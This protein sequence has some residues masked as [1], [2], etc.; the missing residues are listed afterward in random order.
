MPTM[1]HNDNYDCVV[2]NLPYE[3]MGINTNSI[4]DYDKPEDFIAKRSNL[5]GKTMSKSVLMN[6]DNSM[7][8][9]RRNFIYYALMKMSPIFLQKSI[10][11]NGR[12][13][14]A[15]DK[16]TMLYDMG[17]VGGFAVLE[18]LSDYTKIVNDDSNNFFMMDNAATHQPNML[19]YPEFMPLPYTESI[20][21]KEF[22]DENGN[23]FGGPKTYFTSTVG[24]SLLV[25]KFLDYLRENGVYDNTRIIIVADHGYPTDRW[26]KYQITV[27]INEPKV[28]SIN[29]FDITGRNSTYLLNESDKDVTFSLLGLNPILLYKDFNS[30]DDLQ[31]SY[32]FMTQADTPALCIQNLLSTNINPFTGKE[33]NMDY[34]NDNES[35][36]TLGHHWQ[37]QNRTEDKKYQYDGELWA[38][39]KD[40]LFDKNQ[41]RVTYNVN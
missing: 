34:K 6:I 33:I 31:T 28:K 17:F 36:I 20:A 26:E 15:T 18:R 5:V 29:N 13:L 1:F 24:V 37:A 40:N 41:W 19:S 30:N 3:N 16:N 4:F 10:Y 11:D 23:K 7:E 12:Y 22:Y 32:D 8:G 25:G 21:N 2:S 35:Y 14:S 27:P 38:V 9:L 39:V